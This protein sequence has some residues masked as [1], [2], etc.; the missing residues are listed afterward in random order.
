MA[1]ITLKALSLAACLSLAGPVEA[2]TYFKA[3]LLGVNENP[4]VVSPGSGT[5]FLTL[6]GD[7]LTVNI[8]FQDLLGATVASH[9]HC[10]ATAPTNAGVATP[11]PTFPGFPLGVTSGSYLQTFNLTLLSSYNPTFVT[12]NG[13]TA[14]SARDAFVAGLSANK[15]YVNV[16]TTMFPGGEIRGQL[17]IVPEPQTWALMIVGFGLA[18]ATLRRRRRYALATT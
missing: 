18:G 7:F 5:A 16:H 4:S 6:D 15:A 12:A 11:V 8:A 2:A 10:C 3:T 17:A 13:G 9:I 14:L 1:R